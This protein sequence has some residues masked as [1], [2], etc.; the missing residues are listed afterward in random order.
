LSKI[1]NM[2]FRLRNW[3]GI[4]LIVGVVALLIIWI[5]M[6]PSGK[7]KENEDF[8]YNLHAQIVSMNGSDIVE[9]GK[10]RIP[11]NVKI[12]L[13]RAGN[14][15]YAELDEQDMRL[16]LPRGSSINKWWYGHNIKDTI[17][18]DYIRKDRFFAIDSQKIK[19]HE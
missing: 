19:T 4:A 1:N 8:Y 7:K 14:G 5:L 11:T 10:N 9:L 6:E 18:F 16:I 3:M 17:H 13:I 12:I 15:L 2:R